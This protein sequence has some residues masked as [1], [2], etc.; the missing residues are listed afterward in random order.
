M[1]DVVCVDCGHSAWDCSNGVPG[2]CNDPPP[3]READAGEKIVRN[4][5]RVALNLFEEFPGTPI[6]QVE[7]VMIDAL[8]E[9]DDPEVYDDLWDCAKNRLVNDRGEE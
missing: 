3:S 7:C 9:T 1:A 5:I 8:R 4:T 2:S 6:D